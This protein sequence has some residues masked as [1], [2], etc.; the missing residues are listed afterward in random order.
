MN[1]QIFKRQLLRLGIKVKEN[2]MD[3]EL[4][5]VCGDLPVARIEK[6][7]RYLFYLEEC[8]FEDMDDEDFIQRLLSI[9]F[10]FVKTPIDQRE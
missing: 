2:P 5:T 9:I 1:K 10:E 3:F 8:Y 7:R 4:Y 6:H